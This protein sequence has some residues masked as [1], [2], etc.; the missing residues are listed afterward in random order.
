MKL[1]DF[2]PQIEELIEKSLDEDMPGGDITTDS[3]IPPHKKGKA[4]FIAKSKGILAGID[5]ARLV[6]LKVDPFLKF[7]VFLQD[8][9]PIKPKDILA[10]VE[11]N[12]ASILKAERTSLNFLQHLSGIA[13]STAQYVEAVKGLT[14]KILD[15]RKTVPGLRVLEKYAVSMGGGQ[16]HRLN[17]S[18]MVLIK[19]NHI[20]ILRHQGMKIKDI[21]RQAR[22]GVSRN[23]RIEIETTNP[24]DALE[25]AL[26]GADIVMLDN[27]DL[28]SMREAVKLVNHV[29]IVE[30]S[31]GVNLDTVRAI[32]GTGV[33]WISVGAVTHSAKALDISLELET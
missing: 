9:R 16:N 6:F 1:T 19:D 20:A 27:M 8:G 12:V 7:S 5:I 30:A 26:A 25:A 31:G 28:D 13:T 18:D 4:S 33:D 3:L 32:A 23:I 21:V 15:T 11:G 24:Q 29:A 10:T 17:L 2:M 14:V 22:A